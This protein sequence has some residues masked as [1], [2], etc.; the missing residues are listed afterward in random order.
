SEDSSGSSY[1][2]ALTQLC[3]PLLPVRGHAMLSLASL[4]NHRDPKAMSKVDTL[5]KIFEEQLAHD[6]SYIYL[7]AVQGLVALAGL[8]PDPV[9]PHLARQFATCAPAIPQR[10]PEL[11]MKLGEALVRATRACG[12]LVPR[13]SQHLISSLLT[14]ARD[15]EPMVR[16]SSLSN[17]GDVCKL[18]RFSIGPILQEVCLQKGLWL[19]LLL[20]GYC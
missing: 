19:R 7:A 15:A 16:A 5:L 11:R 18:L 10:S 9:L 8:R 14:G 2:E 4:I 1:D 17:L 20:C 6:D 12:P 3:D 13:F